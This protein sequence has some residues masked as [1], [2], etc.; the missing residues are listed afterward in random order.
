MPPIPISL[1]IKYAE[2]RYGILLGSG[3]GIYFV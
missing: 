3:S 2:A 1:T